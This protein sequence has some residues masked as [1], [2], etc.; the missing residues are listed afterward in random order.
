MLALLGF[1]L[2][3]ALAIAIAPF[4]LGFIGTML[5]L[6]FTALLYLA[7]GCPK[8]EAPKPSPAQQAEADRNIEQIE[9]WL[10]EERD[11]AGHEPQKRIP[12]RRGRRHAE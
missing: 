3:L 1:I 8:H 12:R 6:L 9:A 2:A 5:A 7:A 10:E 11:D 4:I